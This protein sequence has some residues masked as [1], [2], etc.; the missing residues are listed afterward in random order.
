MK[1]MDKFIDWVIGFVLVVCSIALLVIVIW[2]IY[3]ICTDGFE[4]NK[5]YVVIKFSS[6]QVPD[7]NQED[8]TIK[9]KGN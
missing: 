7:N 6:E 8:G 9:I 5:K 4:D 3:T 1:Y 2:F